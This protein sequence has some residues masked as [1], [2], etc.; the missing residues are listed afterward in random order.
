M[1][2]SDFLDTIIDPSSKWYSPTEM[3]IKHRPGTHFEYSNLGFALLGY[4]LERTTKVDF[5]EFTQKHIFDPLEMTSTTWKLEEVDPTEHA[6]YYLENYNPCPDYSVLTMPDGGLYSNT[7]DLTKFLQEAI[8]G[9]AGRGKILS[10]ASYTEMFRAQ[11][12]LIEIEG[13]LGW[14]LSFPCCIGHGG[15]DF[16]TATLMYFEPRTGL[17]RILFS[18][19]SMETE[20]I[21]DAFYGMMGLLFEK[22]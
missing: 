1:S 19:T 12:N 14:D 21:A 2:L 7:I 6:T 5:M 8:K 13:G 9:Y 20:L 3:Y 22:E 10:Q 18:N 17:G 16:G 4:I 11:S 15:N